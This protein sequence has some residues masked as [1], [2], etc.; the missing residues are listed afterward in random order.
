MGYF[1]KTIVSVVS[2]GMILAYTPVEAGAASISV[3]LKNYI[4]N[5]TSLTINS[6][7][8]YKLENNN[9]RFSG[10]D[11][12]QVAENV[13]SNGWNTA[14][15]VFVVNSMAFAD[16]LSASPLAYKYD[17]PILLTRKD[18]IPDST[19]NKIKSLNPDKIVIIGGAGSVNQSVET[20]LKS[21][22]TD[23]S[24]IDGKDRFEVAKK[25]AQ[26]LGTTNKAVVTN[27]LIF[28]DALA[29]APYAA[30]NGIPIILSKKDDLPTA[31]L[32]AVQGKS[33][34]LVVGGT[35]SV[36]NA[37]Y[38]QAKA[39]DRIAGSDRYEVSSNIIKELNI[40]SSMA[41][42]SNGLTFADAL[43]GSVLAAKNGAPLLLTRADKLPDSI[44]STINEESFN[45]FNILGGPA[46][47]KES[48]VE[49]LPN[50]FKL[51]EGTDYVVK[52]ES[53]RLAIYQGSSKIA[54]FGTSSFVLKPEV[55][56]QSNIL[57]IMGDSEREYL[58]RMQFSS[59]S[60]SYVRPTNLNIPFEDYLK[61]VVPKES[62]AY[63]HMEAL[64][65]QAVAARTYAYNEA[66]K[67]VLD[68]QSY[69]VYGG[70]DWNVKTSQAVTETSGEVLR[71]NGKL[72][73][74]LF[75]S[76]NGGYTATNTDEWGT[77]K[78]GYLTN[79]A[80][81]Y[82][83]YTWELKVPK[84]VISDETITN[85]SNEE[86]PYSNVTLEAALKNPGWWWDAVSEDKTV[87]LDGN[88]KTSPLIDNI[89]KQLNES[90]VNKEIK[91][92]SISSFILDPEKNAAQRSLEGSL[93][94]KFYLKEKGTKSYSM[95]SDGKLK[96]FEET[97]EKSATDL[98]YMF[99]TLYYRS[100][101]TPTVDNENDS[102]TIHGKGFG[103]GV[104]MSQQA[105]NKRANDG[106]TYKQILDFYYPNTT[107][108]K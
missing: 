42:I 71:Y 11:R 23:V 43:T 21:I 67:T 22:T 102:F 85:T 58:G 45:V 62:P 92:K 65:A 52:N 56:S 82:D 103:H 95:D 33:D 69:Q 18:S 19:L 20:K 68:D 24:R 83:N 100:T 44:Q 64:K 27:G 41:Y 106:Q 76:S 13:A 4:G 2:A 25:V 12:Y 49:Q 73:T 84:T 17:A 8:V 96:E 29:I 16:A 59:E 40:E 70:F 78:L 98:R 38:N 9:N 75:S 72:I 87:F 55:Y 32:E 57:T 91:I 88:Q 86:T 50:E 39:T 99:G 30:K 35:G 60:N 63:Y 94:V 5:K 66:G 90:Y 48:V 79:K 47:V 107:L 53:G 89:K 105:A 77:P 14:G 81:P 54:D 97:I 31:S 104:G 80:D 101:F 3:K 37:V 61:S 46:S 36:S 28:S 15:T 74:A 6:E 10:T 26:N 1:K 51:N 93:R 34:V 7:G 108:G